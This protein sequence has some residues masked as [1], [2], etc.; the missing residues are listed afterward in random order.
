MLFAGI[1][2]SVAVVGSTGS[3]KTSSIF[4]PSVAAHPGPVVST[5]LLRGGAIK[6][7]R[8]A[9][10]NVRRNYADSIPGSRVIEWHLENGVPTLGEKF[11]WDFIH[12]CLEWDDAL[13]IAS[14]F[15]RASIPSNAEF[16]EYWTNL[17]SR[18]FAAVLYYAARDPRSTIGGLGARLA[19]SSSRN[20]VFAAIVADLGPRHPAVHALGDFA[21]NDQTTAQARG[22]VHQVF[23]S[24]VVSALQQLPRCELTFSVEDALRGSSTVYVVL[25]EAKAKDVSPVVATFVGELLHAWPAIRSGEVSLLFALDEAVNIAPLEDLPSAMSFAGGSGSQLLLGVAE[26]GT[27]ARVWGPNGVDELLMQA[28]NLVILPGLHDSEFLERVSATLNRSSRVRARYR[29]S[30]SDIPRT[31]D[32]ELEVEQ[33]IA[34]DRSLSRLSGVRRAYLDAQIRH[35]QALED[36]NSGQIPNLGARGRV[37]RETY[38]EILPEFEGYEIAQLPDGLAFLQSGARARAIRRIGWWEDPF[39]RKVI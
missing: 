37:E 7:V 25:R 1:R 26:T 18:V 21:N 10:F 16:R 3:G 30:S 19:S 9:T 8:D 14:T 27:I 32:S 24:Y 36:L 33:Y 34:R 13:R 4:I 12:E 15:L 11:A 23:D 31:R 5:G 17:G 20:A 39:W 28:N 35:Q 29:S 2:E 22:H 6:D 38:T